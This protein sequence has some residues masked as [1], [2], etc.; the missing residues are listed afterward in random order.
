MQLRSKYV[1]VPGAILAIAGG[2]VGIAAATGG[3]DDDESVTGPSADR[4]KRAALAVTGGGTASEVER[5]AE[6]G[7]IWEVEVTKPDG[8]TVEVHLDANYDAVG[9]EGD[10]EESDSEEGEE[11]EEAGEAD[12]D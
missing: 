9:V 12:D 7:G 11:G 2:G 5:E 10:S 6:D 4:A 8:Q 1:I 3:G